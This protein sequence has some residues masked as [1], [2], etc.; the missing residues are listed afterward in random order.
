MK[1]KSIVC[2]LLAIISGLALAF[3]LAGYPL[4]AA[5]CRLVRVYGDQGQGEP[6]VRIDP[7]NIAVDKGSCV[8]WVNWGKVNMKVNFRQGEQ[9]MKVT[10]SAAGF[11][12]ENGCYATGWLQRGTTVSLVFTEPGTYEYQVEWESGKVTETGRIVVMS[13]G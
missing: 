2:V 9:C 5:E 7:Q 4:N 13:E 10:E 11:K 3:L 8:I 6:H 12:L 1:R